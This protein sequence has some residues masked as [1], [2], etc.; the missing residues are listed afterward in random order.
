MLKKE[1]LDIRLKCISLISTWVAGLHTGD[2]TVCD[3]LNSPPSLFS[4][5]IVH[6]P[7][8]GFF[9]PISI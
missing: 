2:C 1:K 5:P 6:S 8:H 9:F 7:S 4:Q 3:N